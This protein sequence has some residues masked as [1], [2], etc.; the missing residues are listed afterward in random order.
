GLAVL[1]RLITWRDEWAKTRNRP[2]RSLMR[3]DVLVEIAR[4]RPD[5]VDQLNIIRGFHQ[6]RNVKVVAQ[7]L[8]VLKEAYAIPPDQWPE[9]PARRED[10]PMTKALLDILS[11]V[12]RAICHE[13]GVSQNLVGSAQRLRDLMD[14]ATGRCTERP[15]MLQGWREHFIGQK[16][17][18]MIEGQSEIHVSGWPG[19]PHIEITMHD[20][21]AERHRTNQRA[22]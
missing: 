15:I 13:E 16:L 17:L 3:D 10:A 9:P 14:Y 1:S 22:V 20:E 5:R 2:I 8:D 6:A 18:R 4:R 12:L 11:A 7:L 19:E 21:D